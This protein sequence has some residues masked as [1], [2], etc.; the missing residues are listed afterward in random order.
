MVVEKHGI[1][2]VTLNARVV[3]LTVFGIDLEGV[4]MLCHFLILLELILINFVYISINKL[5]IRDR[6]RF[7]R[8]TYFGW[9]VGWVSQYTVVYIWKGKAC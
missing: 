6:S 9:M 5:Y 4:R 3:Y 7:F 8:F 1:H 2:I